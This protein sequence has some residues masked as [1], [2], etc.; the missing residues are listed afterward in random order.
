MFVRDGE[1]DDENEGEGDA[2]E[3]VRRTALKG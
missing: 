1:G 2:K 3:T